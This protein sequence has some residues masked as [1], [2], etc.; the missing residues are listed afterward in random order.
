MYKKSKEYR[1][2]IYILSSKRNGTLYIGVTNSLL[3]RS[4][5]HKLKENS[6]SFTARYNVTRLVYYE[7]YG[8]IQNAIQREKQLKKWKCLWK[9]ELIEQENPTWRDLFLDMG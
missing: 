8:Y 2:Y 7:T 3:R 6:K 4:F 1:Y 9:I 5:Q